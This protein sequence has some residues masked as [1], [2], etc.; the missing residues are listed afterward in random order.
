MRTVAGIALAGL[1]TLLAELILI[2]YERWHSEDVDLIPP[3]RRAIQAKQAGPTPILEAH[4]PEWAATALARP[5]FNASRRPPA[6]VTAS[7][8]GS[9]VAKLPRLTA[10]LISDAGRRV[11]FAG[12]SDSKPMVVTEGSQIGNYQVQS[13][14]AGQVTLV[15]PDGTTVIRPSF[16][17]S[18]SA[19]GAGAALPSPP[20]AKQ[21]IFDLFRNGPASG[22]AKVAG[23]VSTAPDQPSPVGASETGKPSILEQ[24]R[25]GGPVSAGVPGLPPVP[26]APEPAR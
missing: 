8:A 10:V 6:A 3:S 25:S 20:A 4:A 18:G 16:A 12:S 7:A 13:I 24:L 21:S 23:A 2:E 5:L 11:I 19:G 15:G 9:S 26:Q 1:A 17:S 14:S 22:S